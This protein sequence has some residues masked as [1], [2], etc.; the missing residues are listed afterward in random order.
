M[1]ED[2]S[3]EE[4]VPEK[5]SNRTFRLLAIGLVAIVIITVAGIALWMFVLSP[6]QQEARDLE[7]TETAA[8]LTQS[9]MAQVPT[10][11]FTPWPSNT[12]QPTSPPTATRTVEAPA[13][14]STETA[15]PTQGSTATFT[16]T[17]TALPDTGFA[18]DINLPGLVT[19]GLILVMIAFAARQIRVN[20]TN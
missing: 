20:L 19:L 17:P 1:E 12:P 6:A 3:F 10:E 15:T 14:V 9:A 13:Q 5:P 18:D 2:F 7:A 16:P 11:T 4:M 8:A